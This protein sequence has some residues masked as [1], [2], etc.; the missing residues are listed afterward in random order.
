MRSDSHFATPTVLRVTNMMNKF[1][2]IDHPSDIGIEAYGKDLSAAFE[3][4]AL[5][6]FSLISDPD[7]IAER[8]A[9]DFTV[10]APDRETLLVD[11]LS[12]IISAQDIKRLIFKRCEVKALSNTK[13]VSRVYGEPVDP[14]RHKFSHYVKAVTFSQLAIEEKPGKCKIRVVFDI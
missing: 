14:A 5:G 4:A 2:I 1:R 3:N 10:T 7:K 13:I 9:L 11:W 8:T 12:E 6:L